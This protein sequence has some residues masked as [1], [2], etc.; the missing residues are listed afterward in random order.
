MIFFMPVAQLLVIPLAADYEIKNINLVV[1]DHDHS[2]YTRKLITDIT[3]S[4]YFKLTGYDNSFQ[5][6]LEQV[7][8]DEADVLL[9]IPEGFEKKLIRENSNKL[10]IAVNAINGVKAG[11]GSAYINS[12]IRNFNDKIRTELI[13]PDRFNREP[14]IEITSSNWFNPEMSYHIFMVPGILAILV[15]M[16]GGF[17]SAL[18][19]VKEKETGTMEQINVTPIK[20][21]HFIIGKL[22]PFWLLGNL[23]FAIGLLIARLVYGIVPA[24]SLPALFTGT[25]VYLLALLGFGLLISTFCETQQQAMLIMFFFMM[26]FILMGGLYTPI[27]SMPEWAKW[28]S[29]LNPASYLIEVVRMIVLKG[30]GFRDI[31]PHLM[32]L[33]LFTIVLN[34]WA[35]FNYRKTD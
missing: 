21:H 10:F 15:T 20:K 2:T 7:K 8:K 19:I 23:I 33:S 32:K 24:G 5:E 16:V 22:I 6:A 18:N 26:I 30:S 4:G 13:Q 31:L 17:L 12:I 25:S 28:I 14:I 29:W 11:L 9:E 35:I 34:S 27:D 3:A 1:I